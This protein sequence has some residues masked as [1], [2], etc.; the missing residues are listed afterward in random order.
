M[1]LMGCKATHKFVDRLFY[2]IPEGIAI[3]LAVEG[4]DSVLKWSHSQTC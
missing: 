2:S 1:P 3:Q 4:F